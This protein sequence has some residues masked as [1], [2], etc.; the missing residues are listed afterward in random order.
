T[1]KWAFPTGTTIAANDYLIIWADEDLDQS[2]LHA[3]FKLSAGGET[4]VFTDG[5]GDLIDTITYANQVADISHGRFPNGTGDFRDMTPTFNAENNDGIVSTRS[6]TLVGADLTLF[7][8]P[9]AGMLN[10]RLEAAY[11]S[12]LS[13]RLLTTEG[14]VLQTQTLHRGNRAL[15]IDASSLPA[16]F[17]L[18]AVT[19]GQGSAMHKVMVR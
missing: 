11:Q 12:D 19:D 5:N 4:L 9:T 3:D 8:N 10:I 1:D 6:P 15:S 17:Y 13:F 18:L 2:G 16:G 7:P 14:R